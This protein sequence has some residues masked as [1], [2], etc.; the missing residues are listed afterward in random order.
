MKKLS[1]L[2]SS[3]FSPFLNQTFQVHAGLTEP[4]AAELIKVADRG[5]GMHDPETA[6]RRPFEIMFRFPAGIHVP[7]KIYPIEH[8]N[9]GTLNIFIVPVGPEPTDPE[10]RILYQGIF[11]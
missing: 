6:K 2:Q 5:W 8:E 9:M 11:S 3:D 10:H 7:Q 4:V 1:E